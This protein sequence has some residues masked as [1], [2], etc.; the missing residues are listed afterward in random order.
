[1]GLGISERLEAPG[2]GVER[3][4]ELRVMGASDGGVSSRGADWEGAGGAVF[5][6]RGVSRMGNDDG[7]GRR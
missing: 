2:G 1:M 4:W 3:G 5:F 7:G 6:W